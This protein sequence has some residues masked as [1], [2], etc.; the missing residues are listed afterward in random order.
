MTFSLEHTIAMLERTPRALDTLLAGLDPAWTEAKR[1]DA[2]WSAFDVVGHL[3]HGER[4]DWIPRARL[5]LENDSLKTFE[6]FDRFGH[7]HDRASHT[8]RE[9][10]DTFASLRAE[11]VALLRSWQLTPEQLLRQGR[12]PHL[13]MVTLSE[14]LATWTVHDLNHLAQ[15]SREMASAYQNAVGPWKAYLSVLQ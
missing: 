2:S 8:L 13:G 14:L 15:I 12:H 10:L 9:Q 7:L 1:A 3:I 11:N 5:I 6:P 4:T